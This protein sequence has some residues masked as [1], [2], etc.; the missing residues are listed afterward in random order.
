MSKIVM[1]R[2]RNRILN[3]FKDTKARLLKQRKAIKKA[4]PSKL[5]FIARG[6]TLRVVPQS[7]VTAVVALPS[8]GKVSPKQRTS[9]PASP[10]SKVAGGLPKIGMRTIAAL[11][12]H[13]RLFL[14]NRRLMHC[15]SPRN[16]AV[17]VSA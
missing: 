12:G 7:S 2:L 1:L 10:T 11:I 9:K 8:P 13:R 3:R 14:R 16:S 6:K 4:A 15:G 5:G 17:A